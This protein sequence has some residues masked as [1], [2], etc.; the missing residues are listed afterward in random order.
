M[1]SMQKSKTQEGKS[2][3]ITE[4]HVMQSMEENIKVDL[5]MQ[6]PKTKGSDNVDQPM[7][8]AKGEMKN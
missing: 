7:H 2:Q 6:E 1:L 8:A 3:K 4:A 5:E